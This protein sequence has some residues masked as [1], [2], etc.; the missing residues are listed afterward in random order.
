M[1]SVCVCLSLFLSHRDVRL[2]HVVLATALSDEQHAVEE[3]ERAL[4]LG[5]VYPEG[6]LQDQLPVGGQIWTLPVQQQ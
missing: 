4:V 6:P 3:E 5:S 2:V 1:F